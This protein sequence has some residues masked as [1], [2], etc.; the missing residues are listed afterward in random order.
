MTRLTPLERFERKYVPEPNTGCY[1]WLAAVGSSG[2]GH[3]GYWGRVVDVHRFAYEH[4]VGP[5][6]DGMCVLHRCDMP[7]CVNPA[8][9]FLGTQTDNMR[10]M[11]EKRRRKTPQGE[12]RGPTKLTVAQVLAIR[13]DR[14]STRKIASVY[15]V[16]KSAIAS[17]KA[18]VTWK[19]LDGPPQENR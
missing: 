17:V 13:R 15:G 8:H 2:Y 10:D 5:I 16:G 6:P 12:D 9:L 14:R 3:F 1:L 11:D 19:Y 4:F 7:L 18:R